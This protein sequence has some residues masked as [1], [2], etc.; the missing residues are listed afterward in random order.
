MPLLRRLALVLASVTLLS[1]PGLAQRAEPPRTLTAADYA[2]A[3]QFLIYNAAPLALH[4]GVHPTWVRVLG[5]ER[6][7]YVATTENCNE[8]FLVDPARGSR[9]ACE[10]PECKRAE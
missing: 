7:W 3:E 2:H 6:F 9:V 8:A 10:L 4:S 5:D 1:A